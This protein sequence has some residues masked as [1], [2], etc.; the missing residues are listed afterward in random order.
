MLKG[1]ERVTKGYK[2]LQ[3]VAGVYKGLKRVTR[4]NRVLERLK[5]VTG[6]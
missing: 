1:L 6:G 5:R 2:W 3:G 4:G